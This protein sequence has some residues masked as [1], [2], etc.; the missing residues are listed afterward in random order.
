MATPSSDLT[1][2]ML[3][4]LAQ[5]AAASQERMAKAE[6]VAAAKIHGRR[7]RPS[8][9]LV[10]LSEILNFCPRKNHEMT[11]SSSSTPNDAEPPTQ[12]L[13]G[14]PNRILMGSGSFWHPFHPRVEDVHRADLP[15]IGRIPRWGGATRVPMMVA[16]HEV[17]VALLLR[18]MGAPDHVVFQGLIHDG[19]EVYF[20]YDVPGPAMRGDH[21]YAEMLRCM[22]RQNKIVFR[23]ALGFPLHLDARVKHADLVLLMTEARDLMPPCDPE[24]FAGLPDPLAEEI[25]PWTWEEATARWT[26]MFLALGGTL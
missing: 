16:E 14:D 9:A 8:S 10:P 6:R 4:N 19:H 20:P 23:Q 15:K 24:H 13:L 22:E 2:A 7:A 26:E 5:I 12:R 17:R 3:V 25:V 21:P 1:P 11:P 18:A